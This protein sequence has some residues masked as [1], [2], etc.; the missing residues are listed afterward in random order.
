M[1]A[2]KKQRA[3]IYCR[4]SSKR[5]SGEGTGLDSQELRCRQYARTNGYEVDAVFTDD[6]SGG[7]DF[8]KRPGMVAVLN[9]LRDHSDR[10]Y[11]VIFDDLKRFARDTV[12]HLKLREA[13]AAHNATVECLNFKFEDTPEGKF[14]ETVIAAQGEL[15]RWQNRRQVIQK[16]KARLERG[17]WVFACPVG[18]KYS[19]SKAEGKILVRNEPLAS[20]VQ[21][22]LEGYASGRFDLQS[23]V[24]RFL[25]AQPEFPKNRSGRV[26]QFQVREILERVVYAGFVESENWGVSRREGK[27]EALISYA[28]HKKNPG[29]P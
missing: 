28:T 18:Y 20:I 6:V 10:G 12:F 4:V 22:A 21:E 29:P 25:E 15:E 1:S 8:M 7:G 3:V 2:I 13:L 16:M 14:V 9:H 11:V 17:Y 5:Q 26:R 24:M 27:H 23:E 19:H